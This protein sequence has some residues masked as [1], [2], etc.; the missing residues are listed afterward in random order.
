MEDLAAGTSNS[1]P[2]GDGYHSV[3]LRSAIAAFRSTLGVLETN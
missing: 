2:D 1:E 3:D